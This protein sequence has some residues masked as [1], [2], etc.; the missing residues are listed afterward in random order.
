LIS[1]PVFPQLFQVRR[2]AQKVNI[3]SWTL[4]RHS[5]FPVAEPAASQRTVMEKIHFRY[6]WQ[7]TKLGCTN[8]VKFWVDSVWNKLDMVSLMPSVG[9]WH[10]NYCLEVYNI[11]ISNHCVVLTF[12]WKLKNSDGGGDQ[13]SRH[14]LWGNT[15][16]SEVWCSCHFCFKLIHRTFW[17]VMQLAF[18][19]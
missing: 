7:P 19:L 10:L 5:A 11:L 13:S 9:L 4:Y 18:L 2:V 17:G 16:H 1:W 15:E 8:E 14:Q 12:R 3:W 6:I